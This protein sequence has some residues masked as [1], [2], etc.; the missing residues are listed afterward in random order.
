M[1]DSLPMCADVAAAGAYEVIYDAV[2]PSYRLLGAASSIKGERSETQ[3]LSHFH[4]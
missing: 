3:S 4:Y 1:P 2:T